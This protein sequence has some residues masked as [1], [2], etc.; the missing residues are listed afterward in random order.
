MILA[1][2]RFWRAEVKRG[3]EFILLSLLKDGVR[4]ALPA[5]AAEELRDLRIEVPMDQWNRVVKHARSDRK[6]VGGILLD[7]ARTKDA[8]PAAIAR[9]RLYHGLQDVVG[10]AT[11]ALVEE[12]LLVLGAPERRG[13]AA[14]E[15]ATQR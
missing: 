9:D 3:G 8:L 2:G 4:G 10:E 14:G 13:R 6:L 1:Q 15:G 11:T 7:F 5:E 12:G